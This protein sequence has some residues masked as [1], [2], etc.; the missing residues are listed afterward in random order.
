MTFFDKINV[1]INV[2][3]NNYIIK[4]EIMEVLKKHIG[5]SLICVKEYSD[6]KIR[7]DC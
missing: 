6:K 3:K 2:I 5:D 4:N 1:D 7:K